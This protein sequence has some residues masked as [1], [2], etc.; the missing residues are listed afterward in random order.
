MKKRNIILSTIA[1]SMITFSIGLYNST[2]TK[3]QSGLLLNNI[4]ALA[5]TSEN[6]ASYMCV[7]FGSVDCPYSSGLKTLAVG[8]YSLGYN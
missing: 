5:E 6:S 3:Q 1:L 4:E 2:Q 8:K 7:D